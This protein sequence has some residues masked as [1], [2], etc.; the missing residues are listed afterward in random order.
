MPRSCCETFLRSKITRLNTLTRLLKCTKPMDAAHVVRS[1][2]TII[3]FKPVCKGTWCSWLSH[4]LSIC[5]RLR[6]VLG[7]IPSVSIFLTILNTSP[8]STTETTVLLNSHTYFLSST[9][10]TMEH[11]FHVSPLPELRLATNRV[12]LRYGLPEL[13]FAFATQLLPTPRI[14][15]N[16]SSKGSQSLA[17]LQDV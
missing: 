10:V 14:L 17:G 9:L 12:K 1:R 7:S 13:V 4:P 11:S 16:Q 6:G 2:D 8:S 5:L 3:P 15:D